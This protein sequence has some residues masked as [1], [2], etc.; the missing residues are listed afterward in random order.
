MVDA[1]VDVDSFIS[2]QQRLD[3]YAKHVRR[4]PDTGLT[5]AK[6]WL[7]DITTVVKG[8]CTGV[9]QPVRKYAF[10]ATL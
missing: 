3:L 4:S 1:G 2:A 7:P 8:L 5:P 6:S 9:V 10:S